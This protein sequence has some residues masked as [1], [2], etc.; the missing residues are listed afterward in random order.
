MNDKHSL[1]FPLV[2]IGAGVLWVLIG[3]GRVS[4]S[5]L[6]ALTHI[7][8]YLLIGLGIGLIAQNYWASAGLILSVVLVLG[9]FLS[10]VYAEQL[11]W[12]EG[13]MMN[14]NIGLGEVRGSGTIVTQV[15]PVGEFTELAIDYPAEVTIQQGAK[16]SLTMTGDDDLLDQ[17]TAIVTNGRLTVENGERNWIQRIAPTHLLKIE[18]IVVDLTQVEFPTAGKLTLFGLTTDRFELFLDGAGDVSL[19]DLTVNDLSV[20]LGGAGNISAA[21]TAVN[22]KVNIDGL[23]AFE[24]K[25][26]EAQTA[27]VTINGAGDATLRVVRQLNATIN[28]AGSVHYA[29]DPTVSKHVNGLGSISQIP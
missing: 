5:N 29:G 16:Y 1:F 12:N 4:S 15:R 14:V 3:Q 23:G 7:W 9:A 13:S 21:G 22:A 18:L 24:G 28:G 2:L 20:K 6:W 27:Q 17:M 11:G 19:R 26:L 8:P 10:V 25:Q